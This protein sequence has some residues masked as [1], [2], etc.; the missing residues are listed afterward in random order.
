MTEVLQ[1]QEATEVNQGAAVRQK[2][3]ISDEELL[4]LVHTAA[5][6]ADSKKATGIVTL[7]LVEITQFTDYF[8]IC[9][10]SSSRQV[11]AIADEV[12]DKLRERGVRPMNTEG[13]NNAEWVLID[14]GA[15]VVH[16]FSNT[17]RQFYDL[18]RLWRDAERVEFPDIKSE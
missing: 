4:E 14:Y 8:V 12:T 7:R 5:R 16:V 2:Q 1:N 3:Q 9:S 6:A 10:G 15:F 13:Y 18:E 17:A 11:Q